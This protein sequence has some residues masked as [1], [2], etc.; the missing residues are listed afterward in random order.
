VERPTRNCRPDEPLSSVVGL[1]PV[2]TGE[3]VVNAQ[4][5]TGSGEVAGRITQELHG[6]GRFLIRARGY[7]GHFSFAQSQPASRPLVSGRGRDLM[8]LSCRAGAR[9]MRSDVLNHLDSMRQAILGIL[10]DVHPVEFPERCGGLAIP[11]FSNSIQTNTYNLLDPQDQ[12]VAPPT[13]I[14]PVSSA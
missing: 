14:E 9:A 8:H 3:L 4:L 1:R 13:G 10:M 12:P 5:T 6:Q 2:R 7:S 11:G